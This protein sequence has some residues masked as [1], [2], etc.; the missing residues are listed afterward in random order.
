MD[1]GDRRGEVMYV[2]K[3]TGLPLGYWIGIRY[4]EPLGKNNGSHK[5]KKYFECLNNYGGFVRPDRVSVGDYP[6]L[7]DMSDLGSDDEI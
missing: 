6:E 4:D 2:G 5:G 1:P 7:D 3:V